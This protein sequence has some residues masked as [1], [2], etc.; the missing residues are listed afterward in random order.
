VLLAYADKCLVIRLFVADE[1]TVG[2]NDDVVLLAVFDAFTLLAPWVQL[3]WISRTR[4][5]YDSNTTYLNLVDSWR[6]DF[7]DRLDLL[8]VLDAVVAHTN[9]PNDTF[10]LRLLQGLPHQLPATR[11]A[12]GTVD[13]EQI[14]VSVLAS[15]LFYAL[16]H[17]FVCRL[18]VVARAE[19]FSGDVHLLTR[20][21]ALLNGIADIGF[22]R[23]VLGRVNVTVSGTE[24]LETRIDTFLGGRKVNTEANLRY[25]VL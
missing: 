16:D 9:V 10:L 8:D 13:Q 25:L 6:E 2:F 17:L 18:S 1:R 12:I 21:V 22:I 19:D 7:A 15:K 23:I 3:I 5:L 4:R 11:S 24:R 14:N 20:Y